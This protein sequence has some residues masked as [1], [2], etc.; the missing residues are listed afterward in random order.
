MK[1]LFIIL[2]L[3]CSA[4]YAQPPVTL[5][6]NC[7]CV[8]LVGPT[9]TIDVPTTI[10][11]TTVP[12][13]TTTLPSTDIVITGLSPSCTGPTTPGMNTI[14]QVTMYGRNFQENSVVYIS[15]SSVSNTFK[16]SNELVA[17]IPSS[18]LQAEGYKP[19]YVYTRSKPVSNTVSLQVAINC[20]GNTTTLPPTTILTT[21]TTSNVTTTTTQEYGELRLTGFN[22]SYLTMNSGEQRIIVYGENFP[23]DRNFQMYLYFGVN[24]AVTGGDDRYVTVMSP[25]EGSVTIPEIYLTMMGLDGLAQDPFSEDYMV[26]TYCYYTLG[27]IHRKSDG[28]FI[29]VKKE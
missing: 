8:T 14:V 17:L 25:T 1:K 27:Y 22:P 6:C 5:Q 28:M 7:T 11:T 3:M 21:T 16:S 24:S 26:G 13:T 12:V 15:G 10:V 4:V 23:T 9:T 19:M 18:Y 29:R 2:L 20:G